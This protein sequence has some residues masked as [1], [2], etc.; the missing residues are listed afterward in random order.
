[1]AGLAAG[2]L[3]APTFV[4]LGGATVALL[5]LAA[6]LPLDPPLLGA[7]RFGKLDLGS[8]SPPPSYVNS[9]RDADGTRRS[10]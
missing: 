7:T 1:M 3:L 5:G 9:V 6:V 10:R 8:H 2:S 4:A